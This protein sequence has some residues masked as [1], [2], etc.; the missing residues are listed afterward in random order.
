[1]F[2]SPDDYKVIEYIYTDVEYDATCTIYLSFEGGSLGDHG[3][4]HR[5]LAL[6]SHVFDHAGADR[7]FSISFTFFELY[8]NKQMVERLYRVSV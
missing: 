2:D 6:R 1:M 5:E 3:V 8:D 7:L 4:P